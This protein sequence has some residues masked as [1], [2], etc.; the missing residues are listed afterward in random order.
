[1]LV[2]AKR[3]GVRKHF[4]LQLMRLLCSDTA[5]CSVGRLDEKVGVQPENRGPVLQGV[6]LGKIHEIRS[7]CWHGRVRRYP[8]ECAGSIGVVGQLSYTCY[9]ASCVG[10]S[11]TKSRLSEQ[12]SVAVGCR[13]IGA[14]PTLTST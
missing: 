5:A 1:M 14:R 9:T 4:R 6:L 11:L 8:M 3:A 12:M 10:V 2:G 13:R 7:S